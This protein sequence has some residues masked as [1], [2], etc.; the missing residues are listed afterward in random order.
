MGE[1]KLEGRLMGKKCR[2]CDFEVDEDHKGM[3]PSLQ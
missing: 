2:N 1:F 3:C